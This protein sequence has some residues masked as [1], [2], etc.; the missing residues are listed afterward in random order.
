MAALES[1]QN[2][3]VIP[4]ATQDSVAQPQWTQPKEAFAQAL[5]TEKWK[6]LPPHAG[7]DPTGLNALLCEK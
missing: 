4:P 2:S 7:N 1:N 3:L 6:A 5:T